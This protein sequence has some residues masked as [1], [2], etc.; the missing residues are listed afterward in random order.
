[1]N[2]QKILF[3]LL[4][5][6]AIATTFAQPICGFDGIHQRNLQQDPAYRKRVE[7]SDASLR[8]YIQAHKSQLEA[9]VGAGTAALY[10]I[11]V[12]VHIVH[13]GGAL[14]SLYNPTD[15]Q[16][17]GA[18]NYLNHVYDGTDPTLIGGVGDMQIQF[19]LAQRDPNCNPTTGINHIDG[20]G[21]SGYTAGGINYSASGGTAELNVK[22]LIRWPVTDYYNIWIVN[23]IDG[24]DG[25]SGQ[26]IAGYAYFAVGASASVDGTVMLAT[27][28][29]TGQ[30]T[31]PHEIGHAFGLYHTFEGSA[32]SSSCPANSDCTTDGDRVCD[33]DPVSDNLTAGVYDFTCRTGANTCAGGAPFS[34]NTESNFMAYTNCYTLFTAGQKARALATLAGEPNRV[35]L[36][37]SLGAT[38]TTSGCAPKI[39][40]EAAAGQATETTAATADCRPYKDYT[41][42]MVIGNDPSQ[43]ATATLN[44]SGGTATEAV[45]FAVTTNGDFAAPSKTLS[46]PAGVHTAR[47]F[48]IRI[49]DDAIVESGETFTLGFTVNNGG[50]TAIKGDGTTALTFTI[51]DNDAAPFGPGNITMSVGSSAG[52]AASPFKGSSAKEKTQLIYKAPELTAAG[53]RAGNFTGLSFNLIKNSGASFVYTGLTIKIGQ[54]SNGSLYNGAGEFPLSD[55]GFTTVYSQNYTTVNGLNSFTFSTPFTWDGVSNVV[56]EV[57]YDNG[58][59]TSAD[60]NCLAYSDG[61]TTASF[62]FAAINCSTAYSGFGYFPNGV[63]PIIQFVYADPGIQVQTVLNTSRQEYLGPNADVYFYDQATG[64]LMARIANSSSFDYGCTQVVIDRNIASA[65]ANAV[66]FWNNNAANYLM[67]RTL[68]VIPTTNNPAGS[69]QISLYYSQAEIN[70]WQTATGQNISSAQLVKVATQISNVTP[71]SPGAGGAVTLATPVVSA[72]GTNTVLTAAFSNGFSGFGAGVAGVALPVHLLDFKA[73]LVSNAVVLDWITSSE[74]NSYYFDVERSYDGISFTK[75]GTVNAAGN[76]SLPLNYSFNDPSVAQENNFYRLKQVDRDGKWEYSKVL[77][78]RYQGKTNRFRVIN[79]PFT[80]NIDIEF[81]KSQSGNLLI[82]LLDAAGKEVYRTTQAATGQSRLRVNTAGKN[83]SAGIYVLQVT[84]NQEQFVERVMKQK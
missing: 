61:S 55:A 44:I 51:S 6:L 41:Y 68:R 23:K 46:F 50:G 40:F 2:C 78:I 64:K 63:K 13:T 25:T 22:N 52:S 69:Y 79:N 3:S 67:S 8:K 9:R 15:A 19:A 49:Y 28:M 57:C 48:T 45:D 39:N 65:G 71:A 37:T 56:V 60:D 17:T 62:A 16:I 59:A 80:D 31:L 35:S 74:I 58:A 21:I 72:L 5:I 32:N 83:I 70:G 27:Q 38:P 42:N 36:T 77:A 18:I 82:K 14:G 4:A 11:P 54:T 81:S 1:M 24:K 7:L 76:S 53:L 73:K 75:A 12:V 47:S 34:I 10:T 66:A 84:T 33:T 26:F 29:V 43:P 20:S 30:K